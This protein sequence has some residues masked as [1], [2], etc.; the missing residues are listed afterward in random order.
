ML[1]MAI[2]II[3][4][5]FGLSTSSNRIVG[6][7]GLMGLGWLIATDYIETNGD[8]ANYLSA[9]NTVSSGNTPFEN[10]YTWLELIS[11]NRG[12]TYEEFRFWFAIVA[13]LI[14]YIGVV[15]FTKNISLFV[16]LFAI[17]TFFAD[18]T[19]IRN[20]MMIAI[21]ILATSF[22]KKLSFVNISIFVVLLYCAT[23]LHS[24]GYAF[25]IILI[26]RLLPRK[27]LKNI[28]LFTIA[29]T[30]VFSLTL[31]IFGF[32]TLFNVLVKIFGS[33]VQRVNFLTKLHSYTNGTNSYT[34][35]LIWITVLVSIGISFVLFRLINNVELK[36]TNENAR[37][38]FF[39]MST[40][41]IAMPLVIM[42]PDYSRIA[43]NATL[44]LF[45]LV[46]LYFEKS[47]I[48][49]NLSISKNKVV[50][51][52]I[53]FLIPFIYVHDTI[54]GPTFL[55]SISYTAKLKNPYFYKQ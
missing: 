7:L 48:K 43:R 54:W 50:I 20:L 35:L 17:S 27:N 6:F 47:N 2:V 16:F 10:G 28:S 41:I 26:A 5:V 9:Y 1:Y 49:N 42:A 3:S 44:F 33:T 52:M 23:Q 45:I 40:A 31:K 37:L 51:M 38:L 14:L 22:L 18:G 36:K 13:V 55:N 39:G 46:S 21:I 12:L 32:S 30:F 15:R 25:Y 29:A 11:Y 4:L 19:Q 34:I 8:Y 24:S 53:I